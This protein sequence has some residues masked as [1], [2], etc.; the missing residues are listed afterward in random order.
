M[1]PLERYRA[2]VAFLDSKQTKLPYVP[3]P[4]AS[5]SISYLRVLVCSPFSLILVTGEGRDL[6]MF[7][8]LKMPLSLGNGPGL[9]ASPSRRYLFFAS[10]VHRLRAVSSRSQGP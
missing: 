4:I 1:L 6:L 7:M 5:D 9:C 3:G 8:P 10:A 2:A